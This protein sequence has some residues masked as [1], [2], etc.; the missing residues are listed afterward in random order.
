MASF[1]LVNINDASPLVK[2][3]NQRMT[4]ATGQMVVAFIPQKMKKVA[5]ETTKD[6]DFVLENGQTITLVARTDGDIVRVKLNNRDIP[7]KNELFHFSADAFQVMAPA[8]GSKYSLASNASDRNS[9]AA[10]FAK[11]IEEIASR[12]RANQAAF[13][14]RR[15]QEK[16]VIPRKDGAT[17]PATVPAKTRQLRESLEQLDKDIL[18]KKAQRDDLK[19][20]LT[21]RRDQIKQVEAG[22]SQ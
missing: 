17:A 14:K 12:V 20:R 22:G 9:P 3:F 1:D 13:D 21:V 19:Q 5:D 4:K 15:T 6:L 11:A 10:V 2:Q 8:S 7:L 18:S 16:V